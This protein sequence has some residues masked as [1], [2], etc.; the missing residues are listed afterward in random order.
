MR[1]R[2]DRDLVLFGE[3]V[4]AQNRDDVLQRLVA[5]QHLLHLARDRVVLLADDQ[6]REHARGRVERI[7]RRIDALRG[8]VARQH[9]GG[10]EVRERGGGRRIGQVVGRHVDRLHR[11][12]RTLL[13]GGDALLQRAHVGRERRLITHRGR[14]AAEQRRHFRAGLREAE[15]VVD[16]EQHVLALIAEVLRDGQP[17]EADAR[18]RAGRLV[19]L[20]VHQRALRAGGRAVVLLRVLV[21]AGLDHLVIEVVALARAL[22]DAG[23][24]RIAA[25]R[26]RD[27]VDQLHDQHGLADAGAAEQADL[28]ALGVRREQVHDL[29]AGDEN[30]RFGRL[31]GVERR[32]LMDRALLRGLHRARLVDRIADHVDDAAEASRRRPAPRS[33]AR[34]R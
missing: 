4:H 13:R 2:D 8:D 29:D 14:N 7:H 33:A 5:L 26:L 27:V 15:D 12:D 34:C 11:G 19:H 22:A 20:P 17:G 3:L 28:A 23:E 1:A 31:V 21:H 9:R 16:E 10:V 30:F 18:A 6:R 32:V 25:V 24:H